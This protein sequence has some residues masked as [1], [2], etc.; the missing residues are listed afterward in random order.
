[1]DGS[2]RFG[3]LVAVAGLVSG[4]A[5][6]VGLLFMGGHTQTILS[7]VGASINSGTAGAGAPI[8]EPAPTAKPTSAGQVADAGATVPVLLIVR[9]GELEVEVGDLETALRSADAAV[10]RAG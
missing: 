5:L 10:A 8:D 2:S 3:T 6:V 4:G 7:K 9:T 1:M